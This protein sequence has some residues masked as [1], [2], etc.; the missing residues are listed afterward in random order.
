MDKY[1]IFDRNSKDFSDLLE[2]DE[3]DDIIDDH[4]EQCLNGTSSNYTVDQNNSVPLSVE[5]AQIDYRRPSTSTSS[6]LSPKFEIIEQGHSLTEEDE[7]FSDDENFVEL[8]YDNE[9]TNSS[10]N[11]S[12]EF[13]LVNSSNHHQSLVENENEQLLLEGI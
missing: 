9:F 2:Y 4:I 13:Q 5:L 8:H 3:F 6:L 7:H 1:N 12:S 11:N 10:L